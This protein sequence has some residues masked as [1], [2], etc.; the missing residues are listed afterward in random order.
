MKTLHPSAS[1]LTGTAAAKD[2]LARM[3]D[4]AY[5]INHALACSATDFIDPFVGNATQKW[6]GKRFSVGCGS[7]HEHFHDATCDHA[8]THNHG[9][10]GHWW[11]GELAGDFGSVPVTIAIQRHAPKV[12]DGLR[13]GLDKLAGPL[14]R[15]SAERSARK[16]ATA[17]GVQASESEIQARAAEIYAH[18]IDHMPLAVVWTAS[19]VALNV[20]IQKLSGNT[21]PLWQIGAG[22]LAGVS[23]STGLTLGLRAAAPA[24]MQ[25]IDTTAS[26]KLYLPA[27]KKIGKW[28][29]VEEQSVE[30]M[31]EKQE[32]L[33]PKNWAERTQNSKDTPTQGRG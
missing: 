25:K 14:F 10:L 17:F 28:F 2:D 9:N 3:E 13:S 1:P 21:A 29:G 31:A 19:S 15:K 4:V 32:A 22:K 18:E 6:L 11:L 8:H 16:Q 5:T 27:T 33:K 23:L 12:M 26:E 24:T 20:G 30:R 7:G